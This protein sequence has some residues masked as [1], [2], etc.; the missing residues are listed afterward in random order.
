[1]CIFILKITDWLENDK[2]QK[3]VSKILF[4]YKILKSIKSNYIYSILMLFIIT[5]TF[6]LEK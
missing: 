4:S 5:K 2:L 3:D 6:I 1:M